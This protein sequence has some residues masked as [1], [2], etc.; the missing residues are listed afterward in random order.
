MAIAYAC[1]TKY[2]KKEMVT[3]KVVTRM[4]AAKVAVK[5]AVATAKVTEKA[6][7]A[8]AKVMAK[9]VATDITN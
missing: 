8:T 7:V 6:A 3:A 1:V 9:E 5:A 2:V 4:A